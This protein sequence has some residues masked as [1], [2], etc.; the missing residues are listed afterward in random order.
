[1]YIPSYTFCK[2]QQ[3]HLATFDN[4]LNTNSNF[5]IVEQ[6]FELKKRDI[7]EDVKTKSL[8]KI[9]QQRNDQS[10]ETKQDDKSGHIDNTKFILNQKD[11]QGQEI[12][13]QG[14]ETKIYACDEREELIQHIEKYIHEHHK[15]GPIQKEKL[16]T[17]R[18]MVKMEYATFKKAKYAML[19]WDASKKAFRIEP[20]LRHLK[21]DKVREI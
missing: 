4:Q 5:T 9:L 8:N 6:E 12:K 13:Y 7:Q 10:I 21:F 14:K 20:V 18:P 15:K 19:V 17:E 2:K 3:T 1:M 16:K 11:E